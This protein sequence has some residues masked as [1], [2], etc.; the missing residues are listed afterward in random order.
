MLQQKIHELEKETVNAGIQLHAQVRKIAA[1]QRKKLS[2]EIAERGDVDYDDPNSQYNTGQ[3][4][5]HGVTEDDEQTFQTLQSDFSSIGNSTY[6]DGGMLHRCI[7]DRFAAVADIGHTMTRQL[8]GIGKLWQKGLNGGGLKLD[9]GF[10]NCSA[11]HDGG[12]V[13]IREDVIQTVE[14]CINSFC[15][16][17][18]AAVKSVRRLIIFK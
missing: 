4:N 6:I 5:L 13:E 7:V 17:L 2:H 15:D 12:T 18:V 16:G 9:C 1:A 8:H 11:A 14:T 10:I 3:S